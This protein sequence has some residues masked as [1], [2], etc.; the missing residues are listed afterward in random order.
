MLQFRHRRIPILFCAKAHAHSLF[1]C[2]HQ[3][4]EV[5]EAI[6]TGLAIQPTYNFTIGQDVYNLVHIASGT[7]LTRDTTPT[8]ISAAMWLQRILPLLDWTLPHE[9]LK[10]RT[11]IAYQVHWTWVE[12]IHKY[13]ALV[14]G[15]K[16]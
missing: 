12:V 6:G 7:A 4:L 2:E 15:R 14:S 16:V 13:N 1:T 5:I 9:A 8:L 11:D 3:M 10:P